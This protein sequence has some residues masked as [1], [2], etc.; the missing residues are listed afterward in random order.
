MARLL[1]L[2]DRN[3]SIRRRVLHAFSSEPAVFSRLLAIHTGALSPAQ[4]GLHGALAFGWG[5]MS[6]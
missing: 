3:P 2:M 4:F 6:A 5:L 1:L